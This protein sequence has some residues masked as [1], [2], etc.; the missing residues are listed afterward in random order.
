MMIT[1]VRKDGSE[2]NYTVYDE[3]TDGWS[4]M[5]RTTGLTACAFA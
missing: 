1:A 2:I 5:A 3:R 4:S